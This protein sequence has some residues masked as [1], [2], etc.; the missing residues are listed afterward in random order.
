MN[1]TEIKIKIPVAKGLVFIEAKEIDIDLIKSIKENKKLNSRKLDPKTVSKFKSLIARD[2]YN[3]ELNIPPCVSEDYELISGEHKYQ[4]HIV[5]NKKKIIV[6]IIKFIE[7]ENKPPLYWLANWQSKENDPADDEF[8]RLPRDEDQIINTTVFQIQN[9]LITSS[10]DDINKSLIDQN[11]RI[12]Q[13]PFFISQILKKI[14]NDNSICTVYNADLADKEIDKE[15]SVDLSTPSKITINDDNTIYFKQQFKKPED[16]K[17]YDNRVFTNF[18]NCKTE[19][20]EADVKIF[21]YIDQHKEEEID[22]VRKAK[23]KLI[24]N[25]VNSL[26]EFIK[27]YDN[28]EIS[29]LEFIFLKQT[30]KDFD[31][32]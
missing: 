9:N 18:V 32:D 14:T 28:K 24:D 10:E 27:K 1:Q 2:K 19:H 6:A 15:Y 12:E 7:F 30:P 29:P 22:K 4:S 8:V 25:K 23:L 26:R 11:V 3:V 13:R 31:N 5:S 20:P 17:D 16:K 21:A